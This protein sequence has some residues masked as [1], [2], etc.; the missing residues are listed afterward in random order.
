MERVHTIMN[1]ATEYRNSFDNYSYLWVDDRNEF[2][3]QF[4]LYNHVLTA[5]E[6]EAH[7]DE[8]VPENPPTLAQFKEQVRY[9]KIGQETRLVSGG[10]AVF[11]AG[12][13]RLNIWWF[14]FL[15]RNYEAH[16]LVVL[17][18]QK[19]INSLFVILLPSSSFLVVLLSSR[20]YI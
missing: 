15:R 17:L 14:C 19:Y 12:T 9:D 10:S 18:P 7:A 6:I 5:E 8:G 13:M 3:R 1:K 16:F 20:N 2:M 11:V 4:L